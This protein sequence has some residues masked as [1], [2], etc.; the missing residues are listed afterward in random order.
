MHEVTKKYHCVFE[1]TDKIAL[2][3]KQ[4]FCFTIMGITNNLN[5]QYSRE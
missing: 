2:I 4:R 5:Q 1:L 3:Q